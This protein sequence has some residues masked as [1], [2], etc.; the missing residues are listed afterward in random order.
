M[1]KKENG[2]ALPNELKPV[3]TDGQVDG[4]SLH[5]S[6]EIKTP[7]HMW[8]SRRIK[9]Y[10]LE[11]GIDLNKIVQPTGRIDYELTLDTAKELAMVERN[12][13][14]RQIRR[15]FIECEKE[16]RSRPAASA[17]AGAL[18]QLE[19]ALV[20]VSREHDAR[21][22]ELERSARPGADWLAIADYLAAEWGIT[23]NSGHLSYLSKRC[24]QFSAMHSFPVGTEHTRTGAKH[25]RTFAPAVLDEIIPPVLDRWEKAGKEI[26]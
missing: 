20:E 13:R 3:V 16:L 8:V 15:Y 4:R 24:L 6:L 5:E 21:I 25:R 11:E 26:F 9:E 23:L 22:G 7:F 10:D 12:D 2:V 17:P 19:S 14:G 1:K 18:S